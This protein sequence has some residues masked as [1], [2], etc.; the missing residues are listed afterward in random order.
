MIELVFKDGSILAKGGGIL[1]GRYDYSLGAYKAPAFRY[2]DIIRDLE[3]RRIDYVDKIPEMS[4]FHKRVDGLELWDYQKEALEAWKTAGRRGVIVLPTGAGKTM[5]ALKAIE[6]TETATLVIVP[7]LVLVEQWREKLERA[8]RARVGVIGGGKDT[9]EALTVITYDSASLRSRDL[10]NRFN[11][12]V[13]DEVHHLPAPTFKKIGEEYVAPFRLGLSA[14]IKREDGFHLLLPELVGKKVYEM[15]VDDLAGTHLADYMIETIYVPLKKREREEYEEH[16][17]VYQRFIRNRG[18][19]MRSAR[20]FQRFIMRSG[21]DPEARR[22]L[23]SRNR[24][25]D[26]ALNSEAKISY[27]KDLILENSEEKTIIFTQYNSMVY[28]ISREMLIPAITHQTPREE[29]EEILR[30][31]S[32]GDYRRIITSKVL[33]EGVDVPDASLAVILSGTGSSRSFIQRLG[34]VLRKKEKKAKLIELVSV[35][36]VEARLSKR[37]KSA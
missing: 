35:G 14:T 3:E 37:R 36:T 25:M 13:F 31:F 2:R 24:A 20:D 30:R 28:R 8:F 21:F 6:D 10:G 19:K 9:V 15:R 12:L 33:E 29:R 32:S 11:L 17:E 34:R 27:L 5:I 4:E 26:I 22:A 18:I 7:T 1:Y 23:R 16:Y